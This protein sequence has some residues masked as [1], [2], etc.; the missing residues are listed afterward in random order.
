SVMP[1]SLL[2]GHHGGRI[3]EGRV[4]R[5]TNVNGAFNAGERG[6][7]GIRVELENGDTAMTEELGRFRFSDVNGGEDSEVLSL[8]QFPGAVRMTTRNEAQVDLIRQRIAVVDFG[9]V[10][11]AR[12]MG[13]IFNDARFEGIR[14]VDSKGISDVHLILDDGKRPRTIVA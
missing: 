4:F 11:F 10:D 1:A 5:D 6:Y 2:I 8:T 12:L 13:N 3:I 9:I 7:Q 14:Q